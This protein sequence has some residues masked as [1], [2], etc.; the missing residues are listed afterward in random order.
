VAIFMQHFGHMAVV[1]KTDDFLII[2]GS[3]SRELDGLVFDR[4]HSPHGQTLNQEVTNNDT[5]IQVYMG[6]GNDAGDR[7]AGRKRPAG[8]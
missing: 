6:H 8:G 2:S 3:S 7:T 1:E 5:E 4:R